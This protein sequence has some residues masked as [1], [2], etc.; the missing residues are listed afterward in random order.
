MRPDK[1][2]WETPA[3]QDEVCFDM[4]IKQKSERDPARFV[5]LYRIFGWDTTM[6]DDKITL[7][8]RRGLC[9]FKRGEKSMIEVKNTCAPQEDKD[10]V[11]LLDKT[12][13]T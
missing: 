11:A 8:M 1:N 4:T 5:E 13:A 10:L 2:E 9:S 12:E 3:D 6:E 7:T